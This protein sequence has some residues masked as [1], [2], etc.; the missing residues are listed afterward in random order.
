[1]MHFVLC[2]IALQT[3]RIL[4]MV[5][6][7]RVKIFAEA[8]KILVWGLRGHIVTLYVHPPELLAPHCMRGLYVLPLLFATT[9]ALH[10]GTEGS[11]WGSSRSLP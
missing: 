5:R 8:V 3:V 7:L 4:Q 6:L 1:M 10:C 2:R 9:N 11:W